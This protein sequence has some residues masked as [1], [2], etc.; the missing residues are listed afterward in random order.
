MGPLA[1]RPLP[2]T[3]ARNELR[4][5]RRLGA[6]APSVL[7]DLRRALERFDKARPRLDY[8]NRALR[9]LLRTTS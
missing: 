7:R 6:T 9:P 5:W 3:A 4:F 1:G 2:D 8:K